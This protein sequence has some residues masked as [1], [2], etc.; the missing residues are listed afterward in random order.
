[1]LKFKQSF[2]LLKLYLYLQNKVKNK[3]NK[4]KHDIQEWTEMH[5]PKNF[6]FRPNQLETIIQII[7]AYY[8]PNISSFV[9]EAP[10]GSGKSIIAIIVAAMLN[11]YGKTG[12]ILA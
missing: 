9:L 2:F 12:Y 4:L 10:T 8:T 7:I 11:K 5:M 3:I 6:V 1:M